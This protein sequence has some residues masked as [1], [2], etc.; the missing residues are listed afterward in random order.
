MEKDIHGFKNLGK[1][2]NEQTQRNSCPNTSLNTRKLKK[3]KNCAS[4]QEKN[5]LC[6]GEKN[7]Q[8]DS[9]CLLRKHET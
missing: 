4:S 3:K 9:E 1:T 2:L 5:T 8:N 7:T 6:K